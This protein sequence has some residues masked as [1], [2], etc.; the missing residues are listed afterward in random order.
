M[1]E[2]STIHGERLEDFAA[3]MERIAK[4][5]ARRINAE[6]ERAEQGLAKL[7]LTLIELLRQLL[8]RQAVRR[9]E[10]GSLSADEV[11]RLGLTLMKLEAKMEELKSLFGL[12][13]Q[14]LNLNLG[15]FGDLL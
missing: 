5:R 6:P 8:E 12:H 3:E 7:V 2:E 10:A 1:F 4:P 15:P 13:D 14:D 9:V 11:E